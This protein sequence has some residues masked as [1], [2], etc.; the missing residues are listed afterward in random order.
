MMLVV[1]YPELYWKFPMVRL[2]VGRI[3]GW[4][5]RP[6]QTAERTP[7]RPILPDPQGLFGRGDRASGQLP[8]EGM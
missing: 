7:R 5:P 1:T 2:L 3:E 8:V 4:R 6:T